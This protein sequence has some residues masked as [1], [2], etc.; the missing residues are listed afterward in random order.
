MR[1]CKISAIAP[2][3]ARRPSAS[4]DAVSDAFRAAE[5]ECG[6]LRQLGARRIAAREQ[7]ARGA[8][9]SLRTR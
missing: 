7:E 9:Q 3:P 2:P 8:L 6:L 1:D 4:Y 5:A